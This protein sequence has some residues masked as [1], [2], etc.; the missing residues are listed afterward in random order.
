MKRIFLSFLIISWATFLFSQAPEGFNYSAIVRDNSGN[1]LTNQAVSFRFSI[2]QGN[3]T[4]S[5][6]YSETHNV[7]T[8]Q[9][10]Q[11]SLIIGNG[12][13]LAGV[14]SAI[15]WGGD[16]FFLKVE[17]DKA[18]GS[19][20]VEMGISQLLSVPYALYAKTA[21]GGGGPGTGDI[22]ITAGN[23]ITLT[24]S[25]TVDDPYVISQRSH[26]VGESYGG[27]IVFYVYDNGR[28]GLIASTTDQDPA[29]QWYNGTKRYTNT[30]G[31]GIGAGK[32]NTMLIVAIQT[33]DDPVGNF[34]AK[35]CADYSVTAIGE[36]FGDWYLPSKYELA[37]LF[38]QKDMIG[39][40]TSDYYWSSTEFSSISAWCQD[41][42]TGIS[43]NIIKSFPF[44]VRA[45]RAF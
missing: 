3:V 12:A 38:M 15:N 41:F 29:I 28:H 1:P 36:N 31:D 32:M 43:S 10:G 19:S 42:S 2:I 18:G 24:G 27:G 9:F 7:V 26:Y 6:V 14:F 23:N 40:F 30:T 22:N 33:D 8:D 21:G 34:A 35:V 17:L 11:V 44:G 5:V 16:A 20:F 25:G 13:I 45:I 39:N 37:I 4:G